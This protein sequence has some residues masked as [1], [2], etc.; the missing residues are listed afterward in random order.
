[1]NSEFEIRGLKK[2]EIPKLKNFAPDDW[3]FEFDSFL[4]LHYEKEYFFAI[5]MVKGNKIIATANALMFGNIGW[6]ANIIVDPAY[7]GKGL[8]Q[9][10]TK[11]LI[12]LMFKKVESIVLIATKMGEGLYKKLGFKTVDSYS[13][14]EKK[15]IEIEVSKNIIPFNNKHLDAILQL[16]FEAT[17]EN[18]K[19]FLQPF[20]HNLWMYISD[21][22]IVEGFYIHG[23]G[24]G[25]IIASN[26][27][28]GKA[29]LEFKH[30]KSNS[31]TVVPSSNYA[32]IEHLNKL[33]INIKS[34]A[35]R[36]LLGKDILWKPEY[37]YSRIAGYCG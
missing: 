21:N 19:K 23:F 32:A 18:R 9:Q 5:V 28:A 31:R 34:Q 29:L 1:M 13:F 24:D 4:H 16:D 17:A 26:D 10:I 15:K 6:A 33:G 25:T 11:H 22:G 20:M 36:M 3:N 2:S 35:N 12:D 37:V 27:K 8:G 14:Y 30:S 7:Q